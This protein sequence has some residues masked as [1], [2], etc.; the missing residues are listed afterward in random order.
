MNKPYSEAC[1]Q[2]KHAIL[3]VIS[4]IL[5]VY[6]HV[7]EVGSGTGQH[8]IYFA[9]MMPHLTWYTSDCS[10]YLAGINLWLSAS[11]L[12]NVIAPV[13]LNVSTSAWPKDNVDAVFTANSIHIMNQQDVNNLFSGVANLL[14]QK[15]CFIIYGPFNYKG[16]Y[17]S[18][19][20]QRFD[21][22]LKNRDYQSGIKNFEEIEILAKKNGMRLISDYSMPANNRI[23]H[24]IKQ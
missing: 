4:P 19:S 5:S 12:N 16:A 8:A 1:D 15:G 6:T 9:E 10:P 23:L 14:S 11:T 18:D 3:D 13:E 21:Q 24:F 22:W 2:N 17:T 7:F 20:N